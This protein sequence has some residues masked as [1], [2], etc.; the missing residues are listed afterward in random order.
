MTVWIVRHWNIASALILVLSAAWIWVTPAPDSSTTGRIP[1]PQVGFPAPDF[2][3]ETLDGETVS[4]SD[5]RGQAVLLNLWA[6]WCPPCR[7]EM[8]AIEATYLDY[9]KQGFVVLAVNATNQDDRRKIDEFIAQQGLTFPVL[10]D[11]DGRVSQLYQLRS[12]PTSFFI[13]REGIIRDVVVGGPMSEA[14]IRI[15]VE[16]LLQ[17]E[18]R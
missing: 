17:A 9:A 15:R 7:A 8:P 4:L 14:R 16:E 1:V 3:L 10:L 13:D 11:W 6:T 2:E 5:F 12:L 18:A